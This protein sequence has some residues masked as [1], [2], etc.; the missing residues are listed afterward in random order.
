MCSDKLPLGFRF[1][2]PLRKRSKMRR[3]SPNRGSYLEKVNGGRR[4]A[5]GRGWGVGRKERKK[6]LISA[7]SQR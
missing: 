4:N 1:L 6:M 2:G 3:T 5:G 7:N